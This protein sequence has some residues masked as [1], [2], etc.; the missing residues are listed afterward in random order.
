MDWPTAD[1]VSYWANLITI[2]GLPLTAVALLAALRQLWLSQRTGS[3]TAVMSIHDTL[4]ACWSDYFRAEA[5]DQSLAFGDLC[6]TFEV[7]CAAHFDKVFFG[8]SGEVLHAYLLSNLKLIEQHDELREALLGL[9]E[10][11]T[12]FIHVRLF[13]KQNRKD[14]RIVR[15]AGN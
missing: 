4:R 15:T 12:T 7:A 8:K 13:L 2:F 3:V 11:P 9:L 5:K 10:D 6:N 14:F 1:Q